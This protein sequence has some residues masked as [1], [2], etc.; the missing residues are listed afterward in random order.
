MESGNREFGKPRS[1]KLETQVILLS[2]A[3]AMFAWVMQALL[4]F[5]FHY[6]GDLTYPQL[7]L[8]RLPPREIYSRVAIT[9]S[10]LVAGAIVSRMVRRVEVA[11]DQWSHLYSCLR[12]LREI[13]YLITHARERARIVRGVCER[14]VEYRGFERV[15]IALSGEATDEAAETQG[16]RSPSRSGE[17]IVTPLRCGSDVFGELDATLPADL[18][19]DS[20][21]REFLEEVAD[22]VAFALHSLGIDEERERRA[23]I[24]RALY[25]VAAGLRTARSRNDLPE[26]L[27]YGLADVLDTRGIR[28]TFYDPEARTIAQPEP[29]GRSAT[30]PGRSCA[31]PG[32]LA[33]AVAR[34]G[35]AKRF[36]RSDIDRM[37]E[38]GLIKDTGDLPEVWVGAPFEVAREVRGVVSLGHAAHGP[39]V[40]GDE[41]EILAFVADQLGKYL[42]RE[43][44]EGAIREQ[45]ERLQTI[46]DTVPAYISYKDA[47]R[48]Y[49]KVNKALADMTGVPESKWFGKTLEEVLPDASLGGAWND[50]EVIRTGQPRL[51]DVEVIEIDG[52]MRW[53]RTDRIPYRDGSGGIVGVIGFS[54][55]VTERREM[56][57]ALA[58]K[59]E[60]LRQSQKMEA[61][62]LLAGGIAHDFNNL[63]TAILGYAELSLADADPGDSIA[64]SLRGIQEAAGRAASLT[65][66]LLAFSRR[67]ALQLTTVDLGE[68]VENI[69]SMLGRL[70]GEDIDLVIR[71]ADGVPPINGDPAQIE[72]IIVN[73]AVN[74][75][76]A[77][78][79]GG[80]LT[81]GAER[82]VLD[83]ASCHGRPQAKPGT[84]AC[85]SVS[86][87]GVGMSDDVLSH[88]FEPFFT[89]KGPQSGTG[90]GL[91]VIY[92]NVQQHDG[93]IEVETAPGRG[94]EFRV[95]LPETDRPVMTDESAPQAVAAVEG[96]GERI[97]LIEDETLIRDLAARVLRSKGYDV[98]DVCTAEEALERL[99][100][101]ER[102]DLVFS[103]VV[104]PGMGGIQLAELVNERCPDLRILLCSGYADRRLQWPLICAR[105][106]PFLDKPYSVAD[107]LASV[108]GVLQ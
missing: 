56:E 71:V 4:D 19:G 37:I 55:D 48:R 84:F 95:F 60:E 2:I 6:W 41:L 34:T 90:L 30:C 24:Q 81:I 40:P 27:K 5:Y 78:P 73:L 67:Q 80:T 3:A 54:V 10:F 53:L 82:V 9:V 59:E 43:E 21:E 7:L 16:D 12:A 69:H 96:L 29:P 22:D 91:S 100:R 20:D 92:G 25:Q 42:E 63:L 49:L 75:R 47:G 52:N 14:L 61:I 97:L 51:G 86:D 38:A 85:L 35:V 74:A 79:D 107:L 76:D 68:V 46:L 94:T 8:L 17:E 50:E 102:F 99:D 83:E 77:M 89:T 33:G 105:G 26:V 70:L 58:V 11:E 98:V 62:G 87:T 93:W 36:E 57:A 18:A 101:D 28:L 64:K 104:L 65:R 15:T 66:Q 72:Q 23:C 31:A 108:R 106:F 45:R 103:D 1:R 32:T 13:N 39:S 44:A 88:I